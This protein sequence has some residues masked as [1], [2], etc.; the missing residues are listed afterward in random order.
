MPRDSTD[1]PGSTQILDNGRR[2]PRMRGTGEAARPNPGPTGS[3]QRPQLR[4]KGLVLALG[5]IDEPQQ[6]VRHPPAGGE[7]H[8]QGTG[9]ERIEYGGNPSEAV[10]VGDARPSELVH[11][12][13]FGFGH[14]SWGCGEK[15]SRLY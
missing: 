5:Q 3:A 7:D 9:R 15:A 12:P 8:A 14:L 1:A 4:A 11:D 10:G 6:G 2:V 13:R